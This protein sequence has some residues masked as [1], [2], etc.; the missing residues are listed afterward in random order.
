MVTSPSLGSIRDHF[1]T[2]LKRSFS[3]KE[4]PEQT[5]KEVDMS[6]VGKQ[7]YQS[8]KTIECFDDNLLEDTKQSTINIGI[9]V[10]PLIKSEQK[11]ARNKR[12]M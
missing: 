10:R 4:V 7:K 11:N 6:M 9:R 12:I 2:K 3:S 8:Q 5:Q 1:K